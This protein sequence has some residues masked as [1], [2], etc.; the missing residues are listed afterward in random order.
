MPGTAGNPIPQ[1]SL[2]AT[3]DHTRRSLLCGQPGGTLMFACRGGLLSA[4]AHSLI[5]HHERS[6]KPGPG[7]HCRDSAQRLRLLALLLLMGRSMLGQPPAAPPAEGNDLAGLPVVTLS[8]VQLEGI[9][10]QQSTMRLL[11]RE[12]VQVGEGGTP[13]RTPMI[14]PLEVPLQNVQITMGDGRTLAVDQLA[15]RLKPGT[16]V[17]Y[18]VG[19]TIDGELQRLLRP[20]AIVVLR[21]P[22]VS[23]AVSGPAPDGPRPPNGDAGAGLT[24]DERSILEATNAER[25][26]RTL[27]PLQVD[28]MLMRLARTQSDRMARLSQISHELEGQTFS[29]RMQETGYRFPSCGENCAEGAS[30][31]REA[32][33]DWMS[34]PGHSANILSK[35]YTHIGVAVST[36]PSGRRYFTQVFASPF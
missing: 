22:N 29:K 21:D 3:V 20:D 5:R 34:S 9:E 11:L 36:S 7:V 18:G 4:D 24:A 16:T 35:Q 12:V 25:A 1:Y 32:V 14:K 23:S 10:L 31:P 26:Q 6:I 28:P 17:L 33:S 19:R 15:E 13:L 8:A 30:T 2:R 27:P